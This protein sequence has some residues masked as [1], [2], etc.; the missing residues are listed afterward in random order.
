M[1]YDRSLA[2]DLVSEYNFFLRQLDESGNVLFVY[3]SCDRLEFIESL[4]PTQAQQIH[5]VVTTRTRG[6]HVLLDANHDR[7]VHLDVLKENDAVEALLEWKGNERS[8]GSIDEKL[9]AEILVNVAQIGRL[10]LAI[11]HAGLYLREKKVHCEEYGELLDNRKIK[12]RTIG[13]DMK[14]IVKYCGLQ[15]VADALEEE[16]IANV[17]DFM[18]SDLSRLQTSYRFRPHELEELGRLKEK[19]KTVT[20][21]TWDMQIEEMMKNSDSTNST[22]LEIASL[23]D[24]KVIARDLLLNVAFRED[25][26]DS[27]RKV[28]EAI[29]HLSNVSLLN[30][31]VEC[32]MHGLVQQNVVEAMMRKGTFARRLRF[33]CKCLVSMLPRSW[34]DVEKNLNKKKVLDLVAHVYVLSSHILQC[35]QVDEECWQLLQVSCWMARAYWHLK[36]AEH[37][38]EG[39]LDLV[40][41]LESQRMD[42]EKLL[43]CELLISKLL[44]GWELG[45]FSVCID[46]AL[47]DVGNVRLMLDNPQEAERSLKE[48]LEMSREWGD[49][50]QPTL[51]Y[52]GACLLSLYDCNNLT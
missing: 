39:K 49:E 41:R 40:K 24:G 31:D 47:I 23:I 8:E 50:I 5:V 38:C 1:T 11:H 42:K 45:T 51:Q 12:L 34:D 6:G 7:V 19:L 3:D 30:D 18:R 44:L 20:V 46:V 14:E 29:S 26:P 16:G 52:E 35:E 36:K 25:D 27:K 2:W 4:L 33:L 9:S 17:R 21:M 10:P 32:S 28:E 37:L 22:I 15:H 48:A 13:N 43:S